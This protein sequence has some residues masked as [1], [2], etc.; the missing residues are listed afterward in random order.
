MDLRVPSGWFFA[1]AGLI[2]VGWGLYAPDLHAN[3]TTVNVNLYSGI[4]MLVFGLFLLALAWRA[5][6]S[7]S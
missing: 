1:L 7:G 2:L 6:R 4:T 3:F 5:S